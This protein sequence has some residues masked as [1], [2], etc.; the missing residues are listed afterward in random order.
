[1]SHEQLKPQQ[2]RQP[3]LMRQQQQQWQQL[4]V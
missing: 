4:L 3:Q 1:V 2:L